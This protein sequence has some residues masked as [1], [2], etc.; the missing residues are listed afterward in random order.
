[1][2]QP[3]EVHGSFLKPCAKEP[4]EHGVHAELA[5]KWL[6]PCPGMH[7]HSVSLLVPADVVVL[8]VGQG[9]HSVLLLTVEKKP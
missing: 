9:V 8:F 6:I 5:I 3:Q 1:M 2:P 7:T 4:V